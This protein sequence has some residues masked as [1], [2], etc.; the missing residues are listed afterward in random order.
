M[1]LL[2]HRLESRASSF[3]DSVIIEDAN[4]RLTLRQLRNAAASLAAWLSQNGVCKSDRVIIVAHNT[5]MTTALIYAVATVG[6]CFV[7]IHPDTSM[8][9]I[10]YIQSNSGAVMTISF[11]GGWFAQVGAESTALPSLEAIFDQDA[12]EG[13][14]I[15]Q[16]PST[17]SEDPACL[18]YTSGSTG[19]PKGVTCLHRQM[20]FVVQAI[21]AAL[22]YRE[23]DRIFCA[24]PLSFDYGLYQLFLSIEAGCTL[25]LARPDV[26]G[27]GLFKALK[28]RRATV[29]PAV[30]ALIEALAIL[31]NR[32]PGQLP[33]LRLIT[34]TGAAPSPASI[35]TL[36]EAL[37]SVGFQLM[38]GLTE[39]KRVSICPVDKDL[40]KPG[41][42]GL[43]LRGTTVSITNEAGV[44]VPMGEVGQIVIRGPHVMAGYWGEETLTNAVYRKRQATLVDL[45][46]GDYGWMDDDG[47]L[48]C[49]GRR[50]DIFKIRGFRVSCSEIE[51]ACA[52]I[53]GVVHAVMIPPAPHRRGTLFVCFSGQEFD[54]TPSLRARLEPY[55]V[56][57]RVW[58][59]SEIPRTANNK[60]DRKALMRLLEERVA[61]QPDN[62]TV[63][64]PYA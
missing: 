55:K 6:A 47:Y 19:R 49:Q 59:V 30:P 35:R 42:C 21:R 61:Q 14:L 22:D 37:P 29:F 9:Q 64:K 60:F 1:S 20:V 53:R 25:S 56:P 13:T 38:Y 58:P 44:P 16:Q 46:S 12:P 45:H 10:S 2:H 15:A 4:V 23:D 7:P 18:I 62:T 52:D 54:V 31:G 34:N 24:L 39:C 63:E 36:R 28:E 27:V 40:E 43:P 11:A 32:K 3:P 33:D 51:A 41:T 5:A 57:E 50:D 17:M 48:Y 26:S 8:D